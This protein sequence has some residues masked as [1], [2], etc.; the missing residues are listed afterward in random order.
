MSA[1]RPREV[2]IALAVAGLLLSAIVVTPRLAMARLRLDGAGGCGN[3]FDTLAVAQ[4]GDLLLPMTGFTTSNSVPITRSLVIQGGW[5]PDT[6]TCTS[7]GI[8]EYDTTAALIAAGFV[9]QPDVRSEIGVGGGDGA[10]LPVQL[11]GGQTVALR[12]LELNFNSNPLSGSAITGVISD[13]ARLRLEN[14][15]FDSNLSGN[16]GVGGAVYLTLE[17]RSHL[18]I[19][20]SV[21]ESNQAFHGGAVEILVTDQ[22][23]VVIEGS[24]FTGNEALG[25]NGGAIRIVMR[26][27]NVVLR[28][29]TF[30]NNKANSG[31]GGAVRIERA[32]N[33]NGP[34]TVMLARNT[35][36]GNT[37][38]STNDVSLSGV[39]QLTPTVYLPLLRSDA[40]GSAFG[41]QITDVRMNEAGYKVEFTTSGYT[42]SLPGRHVHLFFDTVPP[43][44][45]GVP[46]GGPW[47]MY[48]GPSPYTGYNIKDRP[49]GAT[50]LCAL[51][52]NPGHSVIQRT[53]NCVSLP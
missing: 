45:A 40:S 2:L 16:S 25:G 51:V 28:D 41:V 7:T 8:D 35:F 46:G 17:G 48:G 9:Y 53:G 34:T 52:G 6:Q 31:V 5:K 3:L 19:A 4:D 27:G 10:I 23:T 20:D 42:S 13:G 32:S 38:A 14:I 15:L 29:N 33:A 11:T 18:T 50:R 26:N 1:R 37:A 39:S 36:N 12:Q 24:S 49:P 21:F 44:Q 30:S 47:V 22:S 43:N